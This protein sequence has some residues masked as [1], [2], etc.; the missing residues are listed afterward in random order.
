M[1]GADFLPFARQRPRLATTVLRHAHVITC[2]DQ[3]VLDLVRRLAPRAQVALMPNPVPIDRNSHY[4]SETEE[5]VLF[6]GE[7][8]LRKGVDVLCRAW[9]LVADARPSARCLVVGPVN[10]FVVPDIERLEVRPPVGAQDMTEL[11]LAARVIALPSRAE[12][13]PMILTEAMSVG[14]PF[15]S[16][17]VGGTPELAEGGVLVAVEDHIDLANRLIEILADPLLAHTLGEQ[18]RRF[19]A[20]TRSTAAVGAQL[21]QL[22][23]AV[24]DTCQDPRQFLTHVSD[25]RDI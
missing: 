18:G 12:G 2:L 11:I 9:P 20:E 13:M 17:P 16:T 6:A 15:V 21:R 14:R 23:R 22:Y 1:H 3:E 25:L 7:I 19:C 4:A 10:D 8:G 5:I 24:S